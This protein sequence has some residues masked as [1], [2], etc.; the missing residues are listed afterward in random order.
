MTSIPSVAPYHQRTYFDL[1]VGVTFD[2]FEVRAANTLSF[3]IMETRAAFAAV[4]TS[5][6]YEAYAGTEGWAPLAAMT[7]AMASRICWSL[8]VGAMASPRPHGPLLRRAP[9]FPLAYSSNSARRT[10]VSGSYA[11]L[12]NT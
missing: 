11:A 10:N 5:V 3:T 2:R 12:S 4:D 1:P 9:S 8:P 7:M 6:S